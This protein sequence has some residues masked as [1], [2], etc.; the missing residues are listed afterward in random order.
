MSSPKV[1]TGQPGETVLAPLPARYAFVVQFGSD[2]NPLLGRFVGQ[3]EHLASA[4][5]RRFSNQQEMWAILEQML[6]QS[7]VAADDSSTPKDD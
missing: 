1:G 2:S 4:S 3:V 6:T 7:M 5:Q